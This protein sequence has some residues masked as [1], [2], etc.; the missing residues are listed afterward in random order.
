MREYLAALK[1]RQSPLKNPYLVGL[2][3]GSMTRE[4]FL[5]TQIQFFFA[6]V[7]FSRPMAALA[8]RLPRAEQ[9]LRVLEN[10]R[11]EHGDGELGFSHEHTFRELLSRL[12]VSTDDIEQRTLWPEVR[13]FNTTLSGL[14]LLDDTNTAM[15]ALGVIEDL[16]AEISGVIGSAIV[17]LGWLPADQ[18]VHYATHQVLDV[19]HAAGF[20]ED[21]YRA[22]T[23]HPRLRYQ[24]EQGLELG[25]YALHR[26]YEDLW[27]NRQRRW[28]RHVN[29][30]HSLADGWYLGPLEAA[31]QK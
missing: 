3:T 2:S 1:K 13:A 15:A 26:M 14:C 16:F 22:Y 17:R 12:G 6:V 25:A 30:P 20:Y 31:E 19:A 27:T 18:V 8:G 5:E 28:T 23:V 29:G 21:L 24:I 10:V 7:F 11:D 9:R 4:D